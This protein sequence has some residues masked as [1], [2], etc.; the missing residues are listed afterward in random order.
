MKHFKTAA[1]MYKNK[2]GDLVERRGRKH[3]EIIRAIHDD[4]DIGLIGVTLKWVIK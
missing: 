4:G 3:H 1:I 2:E